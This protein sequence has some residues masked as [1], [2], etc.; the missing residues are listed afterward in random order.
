MCIATYNGEQFID[1]QLRSILCQIGKDDEIII[2][3]DNSDD[4]TLKIISRFE[5]KRIKIY[6]NTH[7]VACKSTHVKIKNNFENALNKCTGDI[8]FISD[9]DDIWE[10]NKVTCCSNYLESYQL[11]FSDAYIVSGTGQSANSSFYQIKRP[12][13]SFLGKL[14]NS[15]YHGCT[16]AFRRELL[17]VV[18][19]FPPKLPVHDAWIGLLAE[20]IG[21]VKFINSKLVKYRIHEHNASKKSNNNLLYK[22]SYRYYLF[23]ELYYRVKSVKPDTT[24][25]NFITSFRGN[26][27]CP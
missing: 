11:V 3:D 26:N 4:S 8:I 2:S 7:N 19:P 15:R 18:L 5:D 10:K 16:M 13:T 22:L 23:K 12:P 1:Q 9:Q 27:L 20:Q 6:T 25:I 21:R 17:N 14:F 24:F